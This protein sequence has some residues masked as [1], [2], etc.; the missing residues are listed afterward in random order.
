MCPS[1][2]RNCCLSALAVAL[3]LAAAC[4]PAA[5][6]SCG[7]F[8][9][10]GQEVLQPSQKVFITWDP[11]ARVETLTVQPRF[12]GNAPDFALL[13]PTPSRPK[14]QP[15]PRDF[16]RSLTVFS[17]LKKREFPQSRLLPPE[18]PPATTDSPTPPV[19]VLEAGVVGALD[20]KVI[21]G[22]RAAD[23]YKWLKD[24]KYHYA[25]DEATLNFYAQKRWV[26][27]ALKIDAT[28]LRKNPDGSYSG[29]VTPT[30]FQFSTDK[31]VYPLRISRASVREKTEVLF[32]VQAP[33]KVDLPGELSYQYLWIPVLQAASGCPGGLPGKGAD[34]L[35]AVKAQAPALLQRGRELGFHFVPGQRPRPNKQ[36]HTPT[37]LEW[38]RRL[39]EQDIRILRGEVPYGEKLPDV[40]DGFTRAD[41][42]DPEK[43]EAV[44]Q[45]IRRRLA[46]VRRE[47]PLGY[48]VRHA[49]AED[50]QGMRQLVGHLRPGLF[51][52]RLRKSFTR[53]EM[54][55]DL[56]LV[57]ARL[58]QAEDSSEYEEVL[59][60]SPP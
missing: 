53:D 43:A 4:P 15:M 16:F 12:E 46:R 19:T 22:E 11:Q 21:A 60:T 42:Q 17:R 45:V 51:V 33:F 39:T 55:D 32:Y 1:A 7:Y 20:Y 31:P 9:A 28:Q 56:E 26:F 35:E 8:A 25:G 34:W 58:G 59:P 47:R 49:P 10:K 36:G 6:T 48:L 41:L 44:Y 2:S 24:N 37:T 57:P 54:A 14:L 23:L 30:R 27:T 50:L 13:I 29:E 18:R 38:A 40:D 3:C 5:R 52:T